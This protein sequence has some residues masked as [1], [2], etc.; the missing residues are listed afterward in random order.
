MKRVKSINKIAFMV[1]EPVMFAH[2]ASVWESM[3]KDSFIIV[4]INKCEK[5]NPNHDPCVDDLIKNLEKIGC[6]IECYSDVLRKRH[7]YRYVVSNHGL[8][9]YVREK[10]PEGF[11]FAELVSEK[12]NFKEKIRY[13]LLGP[14]PSGGGGIYQFPPQRIGIKQIRFMYGADIS[15]A[16][17]L[18][19]WNEMYDLFLCHGPNDAAELSK[20]FNGKTEI[21]GYPRY[22]SYFNQDLD[23]SSVLTEFDISSDKKTIL[24]M[25]TTGKGSCSIPDFAKQISALMERFNVIVRPHPISFRED[26]EYIELLRSLNYQVD[27][28]P[29]RDMNVLYKVVDFILCDYGG[30]SFG[31]IYLDKNLILLDVRGSE[32]ARFVVNSSNLM[33]RDYFPVLQPGDSSKIELIIDDKQLWEDQQKNRQL[34]FKKYFADNRGQSSRQAAEILGNLDTILN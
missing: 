21:M 17:S 20:R 14:R 26:P 10:D 32:N 16:W 1:H 13:L 34:L 11:S 24:W 30:T 23:I 31:A 18:E 9:E 2:Y 12:L 25:P 3:N 6:K 15:D 29:M 5:I 19:K 8:D 7:M 28:N 22:D 27:S 4:L 33:I